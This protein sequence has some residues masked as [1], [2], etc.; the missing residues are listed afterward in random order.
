[1]RIHIYILQVIIYII[2]TIISGCKLILLKT[3]VENFVFSTLCS[4]LH[5]TSI[6]ATDDVYVGTYTDC[7][8]EYE[9]VTLM[10][11]IDPKPKTNE[12]VTGILLPNITAEFQFPVPVVECTLGHRTHSFLACDVK[13]ACW[14]RGYGSEYSCTAPLTPLPPSFPCTNGFEFVPYTLVCDFRPDCSDESDE[15]F[16]FFPPCDYNVFD[17]RNKQVLMLFTCLSFSV[18]E[19][20]R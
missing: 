6:N 11:E 18:F 3:L 7:E 4:V 9:Y 8:N 1:M 12:T 15:T 13:S 2:T 10:C 17:C 20:M 19:Q 16:C 5:Y 14:G